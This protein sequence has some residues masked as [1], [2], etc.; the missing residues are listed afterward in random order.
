M[1]HLY[2]TVFLFFIFS[3]YAFAQEAVNSTPNNKWS[4]GIQ[5]YSPEKLT[6]V[7]TETNTIY[8]DGH[9]YVGGDLKE[10]TFFSYG[11]IVQ[12]NINDKFT[13]RLRGGQNNRIIKQYYNT[14]EGTFNGTSLPAGYYD[15]GNSTVKQSAQRISL[16]LQRAFHLNNF[17]AYAGLEFQ[18]ISYAHF[19]LNYTTLNVRDTVTYISNGSTDIPGGFIIGAGP[20]IGCNFYMMKRISIGAAISF[21]FI[22][23]KLGGDTYV[24]EDSTFPG[25]VGRFWSIQRNT[26]E[27]TGFDELRTMLSV[28]Y[29][30]GNK[31]SK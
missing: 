13:L 26:V 17:D 4:I 18:Y 3:S 19:T 22:Y 11:V 29:C 8:Q 9:N 10:K 1:K 30:F 28:S 27:R 14:G 23:T 15:A 20:Y 21:A 7:A 25:V 5:L 12:Y 16:G 31:R 24:E 6:P 2:K